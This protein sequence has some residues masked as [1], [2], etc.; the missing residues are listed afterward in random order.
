MVMKKSSHWQSNVSIILFIILFYLILEGVGITC[1]IKFMTGISCAGCGMSR[2][3][4]A[5]F[6]L[7]FSRA[8]YYHPLYWT[9]PILILILLSRGKLKP[10]LFKVFIFTIIMLYVIVYMYRLICGDHEI[11]AFEPANGFVW[12]LIHEVFN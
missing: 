2:A 1:P 9:P 10:M 12:Y 4:M 7:D 3:W 11:V 8:F 5:V 6:H